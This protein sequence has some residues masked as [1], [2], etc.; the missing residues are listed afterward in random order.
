M[1]KERGGSQA[2]VRK[3]SSTWS[4]LALL[5]ATAFLVELLKADITVLESAYSKVF[6]G[7]VALLESFEDQT[8]CIY[9]VPLAWINAIVFETDFSYILN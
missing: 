5:I 2:T 3:L 8:G 6:D 9:S 4:H 7:P 1:I